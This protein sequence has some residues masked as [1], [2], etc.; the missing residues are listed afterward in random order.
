MVN[1]FD[2]TIIKAQFYTIAA[3]T[4]ISLGRL[5]GPE[6]KNYVILTSRTN[7]N[8]YKFEVFYFTSKSL[9]EPGV[10]YHF[11][12]YT[13]TDEDFSIPIQ[14]ND[15]NLTLEDFS[16][17]NNSIYYYFIIKSSTNKTYIGIGD[18]DSNTILYIT[19]IEVNSVKPYLSYTNQIMVNLINGTSYLICPFIQ[20]GES[21]DF[22]SSTEVLL[23]DQSNKNFCVIPDS[24]S[25]D[26]IDNKYAT[27]KLLY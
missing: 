16:I 13:G 21:C 20:N 2:N 9:D 14:I 17:I 5:Y 25:M 18:T 15:T 26:I 10:K 4:F 7:S 6:I 8:N 3:K 12:P 23:L 22:C 11:S 24:T 1:I 27:C 19:Q